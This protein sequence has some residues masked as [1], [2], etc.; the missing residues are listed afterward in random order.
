A[1]TRDAQVDVTVDQAREDRETLGVDME[2]VGRDVHLITGARRHH[3][4]FVDQNN[5]RV[6]GTGGSWIVERISKDSG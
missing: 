4:A 6:G 5:R 2:G 1:V 3:T